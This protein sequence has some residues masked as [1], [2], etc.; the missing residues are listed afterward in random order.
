MPIAALLA[1]AESASEPSKVPFYVAG[2]L[3]VAWAVVLS[4]FGISHA[5]FPPT[6]TAE[7]GVVGVTAL[8]VF[9]AMATAVATA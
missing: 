8:L 3:L 4:L 7:R 5:T 9:A 1:A 2:G 6:T